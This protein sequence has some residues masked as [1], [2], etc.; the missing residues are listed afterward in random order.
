MIKLAGLA[1]TGLLVLTACSTHTTREAGTIDTGT[2]TGTT[3]ETY[4]SPAYTPPP[5]PK[6]RVAQAAEECS[7][8]SDHL[9]TVAGTEY[10]NIFPADDTDVRM[11]VFGALDITQIITDDFDGLTYYGFGCAWTVGSPDTPGASAGVAISCDEV[12]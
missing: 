4:E 6:S 12:L 5:K 9:L 3:T 8:S 10:L 11:C 1:L 7:L 2:D